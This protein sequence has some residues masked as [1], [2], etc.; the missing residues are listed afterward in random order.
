MAKKRTRKQANRKQQSQS[1]LFKLFLSLFLLLG[2]PLLMLRL[3]D[4]MPFLPQPNPYQA[5]DFAMEN[6]FMTC[7]SAES[8]PGVDVSYYQGEI[9][10]KQVKQSGIEFAFVRVGYRQSADGVLAEDSMARKNLQEA[11]NAG[12]KVG[13][14]FFSQAI[15]PA[16]AREEAMFAQ[17]ILKN[18]KLDLPVVYDWEIFSEDGRT[19]G[20]TGETV[21]AC[22]DA[23]CK[24]LEVRGY[25]TMVYFNRGLSQT[26]LDVSKLGGRPVW[27]AMYG[28]YPDAPCKPDYWQYTDKGTVPGIQ[29]NV[30]LN[31]YLP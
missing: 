19:I 29:G 18:F 7:L 1:S 3:E 15:S 23:F 30:D 20:V 21:M 22:V 4:G 31:L 16:E 13:A 2:V 12:L 9:D 5:E 14:Y 10:W 27:F 6:G 25:D 24:V 17:E 8:V 26:H 11:S 28:D